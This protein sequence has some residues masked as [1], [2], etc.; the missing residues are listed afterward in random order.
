[1]IGA[2]SHVN[3]LEF[4]PD[5]NIPQNSIT[6]FIEDN[7]GVKIKRISGKESDTL[8]SSTRV[9]MEDG[10][11]F[12]MAQIPSQCGW[13]VIGDYKRLKGKDF[14]SVVDV[15]HACALMCGY[16]GIMANSY[17]E[18]QDKVFEDSNY[19][20]LLEEPL[21]KLYYKPTKLEIAPRDF[22]YDE[23]EDWYDYDEV[24]LYIGD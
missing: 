13:I 2:F 7:S 15:V 11:A 5:M 18:E 9:I 1:M 4:Y 22:Y 8:G 17:T 24:E 23:S 21:S 20:L 6:E 10:K 3:D 14:Y 12:G 19:E 16:A